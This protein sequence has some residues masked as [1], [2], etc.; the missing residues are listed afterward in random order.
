MSKNAYSNDVIVLPPELL[1]IM[2]HYV[3]NWGSLTVQGS[4]VN[5]LPIKAIQVKKNK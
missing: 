1:T 3:Q 4:M 2:L 5:V